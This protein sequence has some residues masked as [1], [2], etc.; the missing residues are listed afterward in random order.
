MIILGCLNQINVI[1]LLHHCFYQCLCHKCIYDNIVKYINVLLSF[2]SSR[3]GKGILGTESLHYYCTKG[4]SYKKS[5]WKGGDFH[6][7]EQSWVPLFCASEEA[8][9]RLR[10]YYN[11]CTLVSC[12]LSFLT[13]TV[14]CITNFILIFSYLFIDFKIVFYDQTLLLPLP[15][16]HENLQ[17]MDVYLSTSLINFSHIL[18]LSRNCYFR[19]VTNVVAMETKI[20]GPKLYPRNRL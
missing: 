6:L 16:Y 20:R 15:V 14:L 19:P 11:V 2:T 8:G 10:K 18:F 1:H 12:N 3:F 9:K 13:H 5:Q 4:V 17:P 7:M